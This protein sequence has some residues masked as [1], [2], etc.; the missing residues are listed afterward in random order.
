MNQLK[1]C[2]AIAST[3]VITA[4]SAQSEAPTAS[5]EKA[6]YAYARGTDSYLSFRNGTYTAGK[7]YVV[8]K[9]W[10]AA[11]PLTETEKT[12]LALLK[13]QLAKKGVEVADFEWTSGE[14]LQQ[15]L[16]AYGVTVEA[17]D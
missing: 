3:F 15:K 4:V 8:V 13:K 9:C 1:M 7:K 5:A 17:K 11:E 16:K 10:N 6:V 12:E 2:L 14:D